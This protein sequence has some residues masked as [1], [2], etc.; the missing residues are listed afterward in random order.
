[1]KRK[2]YEVPA[3]QVVE[4]KQLQQLLTGSNSA[5]IDPYEEGEFNWAPELGD[6]ENGIFS[7]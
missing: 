3:M 6:I 4:V 5:N 2:A 7:W 1:M